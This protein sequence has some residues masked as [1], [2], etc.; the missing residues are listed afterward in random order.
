[1]FVN[2]ENTATTRDG[3][4]RSEAFTESTWSTANSATYEWTGRYTIAARQQGAAILQVKNTDNDWAVQ[5]NISSS[6]ALTVN[7][8]RNAGDVTLTNP[9]GSTRDFDGQ[10]F[11][12]RIHDDGLNYK[13]WIDGVL[14]ADNFYSRPTGGTQFRWGM[15]LGSSIL[16]APSTQSVILVSGAQVKSWT[17]DLNTPITT[18]TKANNN[19]LNLS[20]SGS[21]SGNVAPGLYEIAQWN[22]SV[23]AT[24][25]NATLNAD[26]VWS[27]IK[28]TNPA[29][30]VTINGTATLGLDRSGVD[31]SS[32]T[33]SLLVN[34]PVELR[35]T[36][37]CT[38]ASSVSATFS[39][40]MIGYGGITLGG[41]GTLIL[42]GAN[43]YTGPTTINGGTLRMG[44]GGT[45]GS[46]STDSIITVGSG[47]T[48]ETN[49]SD[50]IV[51]G[52][53]FSGAAISGAGGLKKSGTGKLTLTAANSYT[54]PT[55]LSAGTL[56][57]NVASP[58]GS[59]SG[60]S[61]ADATLLQPLIGGATISKPIVIGGAGTTV[62]ISAPTNLPGA[63]AV[64]TF[65]LGGTISGSGN[66]KFTSSANQNALSTVA[67]KAQNS[68]AG[69]TLL[70]TSGSTA[71]QIVLHIGIANALPVSTVLT[72]DGQNG[73]GTGRFADVNLNGFSQEIAGLTNVAR[74]FRIQRIVNSNV[75]TAATLTINN[76]NDYAFSGTLGGSA[77]GSASASAMPGSTGG[78]NFALTK[79]GAGTITLSGI[80]SYTGVTTINE[81]TLKLDRGGLAGTTAVTLH[82][83]GALLL[84]GTS[85]DIVNTASVV[86]LA[87]GILA[88]GNAANQAQNFGALSVVAN[89]TL[90]FGSA[91]S[92]GN[93]EFLFSGLGS[94]SA[95][96][97][98]TITNWVGS[99]TGGTEGANDRL[100]F[101]DVS[102]NFIAAYS[103]S[104]VFFTGYGTGFRVI[105]FGTSYEIVPVPEP[106]TGLIGALAVGTWIGRRKRRF[107]TAS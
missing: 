73:A 60:I 85:N 25:C 51:Q 2:D 19:A 99:L 91:G 62:S 13:V 87:G 18:I 52:T 43:T 89:S 69:N 14:Y 105:E 23:N 103:Q 44:N 50:D 27:G 81:G 64:S 102:S 82:S 12:V 101:D 68:Y 107:P 16:T 15:Y 65:T 8:R 57:F 61:M 96:S 75:S 77:A 35:V 38:I 1:M 79:K 88:F 84:N 20:A 86:N 7:N 53:D 74:D 92:G 58:F 21:W 40:S 36:Q 46:L 76:S 30:Q 55:T 5:L 100:V 80:N 83:T 72:I 22:S 28:I 54:G 70:D 41:S 9:D 47:A 78:N 90:D 37:P 17:G 10:G 97:R 56:A 106:A 31:M 93:D 24:N 66:I 67:L 63:G 48:Y 71:S 94:H 3:S 6:G 104:D 95:G 45:T 26:Q 11:D 49:R 42:T 98:L 59:T 34:C 4:T 39:D 33:R 29:T 32:A